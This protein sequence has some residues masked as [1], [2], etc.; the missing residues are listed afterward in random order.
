MGTSDVK[1][2]LERADFKEDLNTNLNPLRKYLRLFLMF[3]ATPANICFV[4]KKLFE[5]LKVL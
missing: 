4:L 2:N 5:Y 3:P 1:G